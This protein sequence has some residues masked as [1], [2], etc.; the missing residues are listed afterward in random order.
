MH[1]HFSYLFVFCDLKFLKVLLMT[2]VGLIA[3]GLIDWSMS[4]ALSP[5]N[6]QHIDTD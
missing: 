3:A 5:S 6:P 4:F 1:L 2:K